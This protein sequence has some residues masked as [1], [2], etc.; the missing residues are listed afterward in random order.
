MN[1][2]GFQGWV[3]IQPLLFNDVKRGEVFEIPTGEPCLLIESVAEASNRGLLTGEQEVWAAKVNLQRGYSLVYI[4]G[5][6][7]GLMPHHFTRC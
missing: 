7:R 5:Q 2:Q 4:R 6:V 3:T 1:K